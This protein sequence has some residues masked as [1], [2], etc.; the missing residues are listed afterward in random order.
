VPPD[1]PAAL[2]LLEAALG[3]PAEPGGLPGRVAAVMRAA[4]RFPHPLPGVLLLAKAFAAVAACGD[5][6]AAEL[7]LPRL[8]RLFRGDGP[9]FGDLV[10]RMHRPPADDPHGPEDVRR[11]EAM[12]GYCLRDLRRLGLAAEADALLVPAVEWVLHN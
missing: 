1:G 4:D 12:P 8:R 7:L 10:E 6:A 3:A 2:R 11:L 9:R 5:G